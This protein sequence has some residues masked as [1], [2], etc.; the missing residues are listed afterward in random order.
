MPALG[1]LSTDRCLPTANCPRPGTCGAPVPKLY[2]PSVPLATPNKRCFALRVGRRTPALLLSSLVLAGCAQSP[3][4]S[5]RTTTTTTTST[6]PSTVTACT[7][8]QMSVS[9]TWEGATGSLLGGIWFTNGG[10]APCFLVG[11]LT[12]TLVDQQGQSLAVDLRHGP[13]A[14]ELHPPTT[15]TR[16]ELNPGK[17]RTAFVALQWFNWCGP[18]PGRVSAIATLQSGQKLGPAT[19][20]TGGS[21]CDDSSTSSFM[22]EG[23]VQLPPS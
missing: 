18:N 9:G 11:Y 19:M 15:P 8:S 2:Q 4:A 17:P 13:P 3:S 21:R 20:G 1:A 5:Q 6:I 7:A 16:V 23:P 12:I 10:H 14:A 22:T